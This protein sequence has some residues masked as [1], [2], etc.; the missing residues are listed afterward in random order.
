MIATV[1]LWENENPT[2]Y[3]Q[4]M[5]LKII[6]HW[7]VGKAILKCMFHP[8]TAKVHGLACPRKN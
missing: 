5:S 1:L 2:V 4:A 8:A 3:K 6:G 7:I